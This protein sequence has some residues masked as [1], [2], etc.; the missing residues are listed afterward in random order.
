MQKNLYRSDIEFMSGYHTGKVTESHELYWIPEK[1]E[2]RAFKQ[3]IGAKTIFKYRLRFF[4]SL[5][6]FIET[7]SADAFTEEERRKVNEMRMAD[8]AA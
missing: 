5:E 6:P 7:F 3:A 4:Q 8:S 1:M 2:L